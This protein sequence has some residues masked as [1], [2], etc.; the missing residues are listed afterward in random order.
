MTNEITKTLNG[1]E[2]KAKVNA[3]GY[4]LLQNVNGNW[5][6]VAQNARTVRALVDHAI[7]QEVAKIRAGM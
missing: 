5:K 3:F 6:S 2:Y 4:A 1:V 7:R